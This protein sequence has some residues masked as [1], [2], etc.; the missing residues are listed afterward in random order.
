MVRLKKLTMVGFRSFVNE[1]VIEFPEHGLIG[2]RGFNLD[3]QGSSGSG[4]STIGYAIA[5]ALG[6]CPYPA[7][8]LQ[9]NLTA[10][11]MQVD[12]ELTCDEGKVVIRRGSINK[13]LTPTKTI[14]SAKAIQEKI[15][16]IVG[17]PLDFLAALTFHQQKEPGVFL[18]M[19]D[20]A[21][22]EFLAQ[23]LGL[24]E[25]ET[26]IETANKTAKVLEENVGKLEAAKGVLTPL[27]IEPVSVTAITNELVHDEIRGVNEELTTAEQALKG[28]ELLLHKYNDEN[29]DK[30]AALKK[31][32]SLELEALK[33]KHETSRSLDIPPDVSVKN[34]TELELE[35]AIKECDRRIEILRKQTLAERDTHNKSLNE[36]NARYNKY[37]NINGKF[38]EVLRQIEIVNK[39]ITEAESQKCVTCGQK[40]TDSGENIQVWK[41]QLEK[42]DQELMVCRDAAMQTKILGDS[43]Q[44]LKANLTKFESA[45]AA[46]LQDLLATH[47]NIFALLEQE[48][49]KRNS[50]LDT[51]HMRRGLKEAKISEE[52]ASLTQKH[53]NSLFELDKLFNANTASASAEYNLVKSHIAELNAELLKLEAT[54]QKIAGDND[55][56]RRGYEEELKRY[57]ETKDKIDKINQQKLD[58]ERQLAIEKDMSVALK[59][60][61]G[62]IF[63]EVLEEISNETNELLKQVPNVATTTIQFTSEKITGKGVAKQEIR[64]IIVKSG[65]A[66]P[67]KA[68]L[69]G[70]QFTS[71]DLAV[72]LA[73]GIVVSRRTDK[74]PGWLILDESFDGHD[75]PVKEACLAMLKKVAN[76]R[77]I[78][79]ID[80]TS[81]I[82]EMFDS[83]VDVKSRNDTSWVDHD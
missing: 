22:K 60:F 19:A 11:P 15:K 26:G 51:W 41:G 40:W 76:D 4:K 6:Y 57:N 46:E 24:E 81:E 49:S 23:L 3:T 2:V 38:E 78:I 80:H 36:L 44:I 53:Q 59:S 66:I 37:F 69:S 43:I 42:L 77:L 21:K 73:V 54:F 83:Y 12:L 34:S 61:L 74:T 8:T 28:W 9:S 58:F 63:D 7:T 30:I 68:G 79:I 70:G 39:N 72:D 14:T 47:D 35:I 48:R 17:L 33:G 56:K 18:S 16:E 31:K 67:L 20:G 32:N 65:R 52:L 71:V 82:K 10:Q 55:W 25:I 50:A 1:E 27:L 75:V 45:K 64:P 29:F 62:S 5:Y 13:V